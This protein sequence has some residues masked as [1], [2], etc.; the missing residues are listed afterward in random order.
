MPRHQA[1]DG[2][3]SNCW[4]SQMQGTVAA[5][6]TEDESS[7]LSN[8]TQEVVCQDQMQGLIVP[9]MKSFAVAIREDNEGAMRLA[10]IKHVS[11]LTRHTDIKQGKDR[12][13]YVE[14]QERQ[15]I[16][17]PSPWAWRLLPAMWGL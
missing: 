10:N 5:G 16:H 11:Q 2:G 1:V 3:R 4:F 9:E 8:V 15:G 17:F 13:M 7:G 12:V 6:T 14:A